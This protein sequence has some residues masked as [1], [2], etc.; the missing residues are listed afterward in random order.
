M[1]ETTGEQNSRYKENHSYTLQFSACNSLTIITRKDFQCLKSQKLIRSSPAYWQG[2]K[3]GVTHKWWSALWN[4]S[5]PCKIT[6]KRTVTSSMELHLS[7]EESRIPNYPIVSP[8][9]APSICTWGHSKSL[10][11]VENTSAKRGYWSSCSMPKHGNI[12]AVASLT[13][14]SEAASVLQAF[15]ELQMHLYS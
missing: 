14:V 4:L 12:W 7:L 2:V 9:E 6:W 5:K 15:E 3:D 11:T 1:I 13:N 8:E 10:K